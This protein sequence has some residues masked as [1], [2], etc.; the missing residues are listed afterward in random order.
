MPVSPGAPVH[1]YQHPKGAKLG[2]AIGSVL[3]LNHTRIR[4]NANTEPGSSGSP[5]LN[6]NLDLVALHHVGDPGNP[7]QPKPTYNQGIPI[8]RIRAFLEREGHV[9]VT[10][11]EP[12]VEFE[13]IDPQLASVHGI[14]ELSVRRFGRVSV[15]Q[16]L[17][18]SIRPPLRS[19]LFDTNRDLA[20]LEALM[21]AKKFA[22]LT[23]VRQALENLFTGNANPSAIQSER[24]E[25]TDQTY[26]P[27]FLGDTDPFL[28]RRRVCELARR[29][30]RDGSPTTLIVKG[31]ARTGR[32]YLFH[33]F[34]HVRSKTKDFELYQI[35]LRQLA[36]ENPIVNG[37]RLASEINSWL[38]L[39]YPFRGASEPSEVFKIEPFA[40]H[41]RDVLNGRGKQIVL[42]I[43]GFEVA[44]P[45]TDACGLIARLVE[46]A[47]AGLGE[48]RFV[49]VGFE[50]DILEEQGRMSAKTVT[51][52]D[53]TEDDVAELFAAAFL[54]IQNMKPGFEFTHSDV[55]KA[56]ARVLVEGTLAN[57]PNVER[58]GQICK[59]VC[60]ELLVGSG[61]LAL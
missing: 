1:I 54:Y 57:R 8:D 27:L 23:T 44:A 20:I 19:S 17:H 29:M 51:T 3:N 46:L 9:E 36:V 60:V 15:E 42:F 26:T 48:L 37:R 35:S 39:N 49:L 14:L 47:E 38:R 52:Q 13:V 28:D 7:L 45:T 30:L 25:V 24:V 21:L 6:A 32:S 50:F 16:V 10:T 58:V 22:L 33:Y 34:K 43:D 55:A 31:C 59:R 61:V 11:Y 5:C 41:L 40:N 12:P 18:K 4:Y 2:E 53:F 56:T